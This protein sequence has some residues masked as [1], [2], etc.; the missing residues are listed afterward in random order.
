[1][2][3]RAAQLK[4]IALAA[5][6]ATSALQSPA[7]LPSLPPFRAPVPLVVRSLGSGE[8][9]IN[10]PWQFHLGDDP[11]WASPSFDDTGWEQLSADRPW[12]LQGHPNTDGFA[13]Y[14]CRIDIPSDRNLPGDL[15]VLLPAVEDA[16]ELYWNGQLVGGYGR[17]PPHPVWYLD[18][19]PHTFGLGPARVGVL[20]VRVWKAPFFS[21][22][23]GYGGGF[24][25]PPV[26]GTPQAIALAM[27]AVDYHWLRTR[28]FAFGLNLLY[29]LVA[30]L[31]LAAW[32]RD[33]S[34]WLWFWMGCFA[35]MDPLLLV[36]LWLKL[37]IPAV[38]ATAIWCLAYTLG[39]VSLWYLLL[40]LLDLRDNAKLLRVAFILA[41]A[42]IIES[43]LDAVTGF[44]FLMQHPRPAQVADGILLVIQIVIEVFPIYLVALAV[45]RRRRLEPFRWIVAGLAFLT[46]MI[47]VGGNALVQGSRFTHW[48]LGYRIL[49]PLFNVLGNPVRAK[50][51]T[52]TLLLAAI[53]Y[54]VY[55]LSVENRR[56]QMA[57][58]QEFKSARELQQALI[59]ENLPPVPG[60]A[61]TSAY[62]PASE[63]GGD[64]FQIISLDT[65]P[66]GDDGTLIVLGDVSGKGLKAAMTVSLIVGAVRMAV[67]TTS[68][69]A[70]ILGALNRR[71]YGRLQ[72]GFVTCIAL[73]LDRKG[74]CSVSTAGHP[75]PFLNSQEPN[76]PGA[77]PL[78][79]FADAAYEEVI[80]FLNLGDYVALYTDGLLEARNTA[81]ELYSFDRLKELFAAR[82]TAEQAAKAAVAFGQ[83]DDITVLTLTRLATGEE[84]TAPYTAPELAPV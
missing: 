50:T 48:T 61:V 69:P 60:F 1:M 12:G 64:F 68:S 72:G 17:V 9:R 80:L 27:T 39:D 70:Q 62:R 47:N 14:R 51:L 32:L 49:T 59:P 28:Q 36:I 46:Q 53:V 56:R 6:L 35:L 38:T 78:G 79:L 5:V 81:G 67:E 44:G 84:S 57:L 18:P 45:V 3:T 41:V 13:W 15:A 30:L 63:V 58:E 77:L 40:Y 31:G 65:G 55:H 10:G 19:R 76:I 8:Y 20:T 2:L 75:A 71:L 42:E 74:T 11:A 29:A 54:A 34:Q 43:T 25:A 37:P 21:T 73:L 4:W 66:L 52:G 83:D 26:L 24:D 82:P 7:E 23:S 33:R 16:Y 22:D